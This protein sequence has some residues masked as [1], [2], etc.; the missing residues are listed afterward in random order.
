MIYESAKDYG[1]G[2]ILMIHDRETTVQEVC[3]YLQRNHSQEVNE[4]DQLHFTDASDNH[5]MTNPATIKLDRILF[6]Y[7]LEG[8][9]KCLSAEEI[10]EAELLA[11]GW[12]HTATIDPA[13]WI[14]A[15]ANGHQEPSDMLD[16]IQF[17]P[18]KQ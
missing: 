15:M 9:I 14:E 17:I 2:E 18:N 12:K 1:T 10:Q 7:A 3:D 16:E 11:A 5:G 8:V 6:I 4:G 13:R